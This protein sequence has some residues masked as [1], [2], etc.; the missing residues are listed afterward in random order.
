MMALDRHAGL[1]MDN[2]MELLRASYARRKT[3]LAN[4][5]ERLKQFGDDSDIGQMYADEAAEQDKLVDFT[6]QLLV[7]AYY[8]MIEL[9]TVRAAKW[10]WG[11]TWVDK[12]GLYRIDIVKATL[13][14]E[15]G[16]DLTQWPGFAAVDELRCINN[17]FKHEGSASEALAK[18]A[19]WT[20]GAPL[21]GCAKH[22]ERLSGPA[23]Q[24]LKTMNE[25]LV[26]K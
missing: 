6:H 11:A 1:E 14:A 17:S 22:L 26:P 16:V 9:S 10:R 12:K 13:A 7:V 8:R 19:G 21:S 20:E 23:T 24:Y 25:T 15:L 3:A 5:E 4:Y 18:F 2:I